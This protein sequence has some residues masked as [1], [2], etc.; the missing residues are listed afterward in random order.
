MKCVKCP[1]CTG[2]RGTFLFTEFPCLLVEVL[3][4]N[5]HYQILW[6]IYFGLAY[7]VH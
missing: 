1:N 5:S 4:S 3:R 7:E 6:A 2:P